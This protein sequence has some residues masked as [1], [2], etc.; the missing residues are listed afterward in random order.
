[1]HRQLVA[2][3][4]RVPVIFMTARDD[5]DALRQFISS[6]LIGSSIA[7][8]FTATPL[9]L[10]PYFIFRG[11]NNRASD[12]LFIGQNSPSARMIVNGMLHPQ[13]HSEKIES[14]YGK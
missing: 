3:G 5:P 1:M 4:S 12:L 6:R 13:R 10:V 14:N 9:A 7:W 11:R 2:Q 8:N